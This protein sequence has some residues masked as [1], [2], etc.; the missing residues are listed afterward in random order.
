MSMGLA[1]EIQR[2]RMVDYIVEHR[3]DLSF[4]KYFW[5]DCEPLPRD[6]ENYS[7]F[8][9][10]VSEFERGV[11]PKPMQ[12]GVGLGSS[13]SWATQDAMPKLGHYLRALIE[14]GAPSEGRVWL[15]LECTHGYANP[16]G[17]FVEVPENIESWSDVE[18]VI[19]RLAPIGE[20]SRQFSKEYLFG[21]LVGMI[22]GDAHKPK[23]GRG[24][25][26]I[27]VTLSK[28]YDTNLAIGDF[29]TYCASQLGLR[30]ER[31]PDLPKPE[32]KPHGF[33]VWTSQSSPFI[34]W[35]FNVVLGLNDG[36]HTTYDA[37]RM[38]WALEA[39]T[40]FRLG[41]LQGIA[42]SDGSVSVAS[43]T[44]E[45]W[46]IPDWDFMIKLL[47]TFGLRGF[48]NREAV[49]L[50]KSQA[51]ESFRVPVF[52]QYL[53]TARYALLKLMATTPRLDRKDRLPPD[54]R[55][56][57]VRLAEQGMSVPR[58]VVEIARLKRLLVSF[59]AAQRWAM[60]SGKYQPKSQ[61]KSPEE[62]SA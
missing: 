56:D 49:S 11:D 28:R 32:D 9:S 54:I 45:F 59:E 60:K 14:L 23:Q 42:E 20:G 1:D 5:K 2:Q 36:Q 27:N 26:H 18:Q 46:V 38:D 17:Q 35:I 3:D 22:I 57:I 47:A 34:D 61:H 52:S 4:T 6:I 44:V 62:S 10:I 25:R 43:Q 29:S 24:H 7:K 30:M 8:V 48:R 58:I 41:L 40:D 39:P 21:F 53:R 12:M 37:V 16:I 50:V 51:V 19:L 55:A 31:R 13:Y 33:Y 15:T